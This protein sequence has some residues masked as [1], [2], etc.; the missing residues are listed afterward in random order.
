MIHFRIE[1]K[2][3]KKDFEWD[4]SA[5]NYRLGKLEKRPF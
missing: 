2:F 1:K 5:D 3:W 4:D